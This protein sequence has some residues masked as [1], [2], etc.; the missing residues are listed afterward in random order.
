MKQQSTTTTTFVAE[1]NDALAIA[2][3]KIDK[4]FIF[5]D[6]TTTKEV[7]TQLT[8]VVNG[9]KLSLPI[10]HEIFEQIESL[11]HDL[12]YYGNL[13]TLAEATEEAE[14]NRLSYQVRSREWAEE[15]AAKAA[16][17]AAEEATA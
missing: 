14:S 2:V 12:R 4:E 15:R 13:T 6:Y 8:L 10:N 3:E 16:A 5:P 1:N 17:K 11:A 9:K 7:T